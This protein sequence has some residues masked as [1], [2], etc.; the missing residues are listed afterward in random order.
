MPSSSAQCR[1]ARAASR[2]SR[3]ASGAESKRTWPFVQWKMY[4]SF[5]TVP[6][7]LEYEARFA[8]GERDHYP[9]SAVGPKSSP[10]AFMGRFHRGLDRV[11]SPDPEILEVNVAGLVEDMRDLM[12]IYNA[13]H[14]DDPI[15]AMAVYRRVVPTRGY[16][17][18]E[19]VERR[20]LA[21]LE[22]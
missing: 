3:G 18:P 1:Q 19:S 9:F 10:R 17:G 13:R 11:A 20:K 12:R 16:T 15:V 2:T 4:T 22:E 7:Y 8:S 21:V 14:P 6:T 5:R